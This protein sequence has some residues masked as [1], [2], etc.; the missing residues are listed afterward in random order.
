MKIVDIADEIFQEL[1]EASN[2]SIPAIA[3]WL[4][5]NVGVLNNFIN[6]TYSVDSTTYELNDSDSV[7]IG[8]NEKAILKKMYFVH[9]Y[10]LKIRENIINISSDSVISVSDD[11]S[12]VTKINKNEIT[13]ALSQIKRQEYDQ[14]Q[15]LINAYKLDKSSP[16]QV[17]GD[18]TEIGS[19]LNYLG[20]NEFNRSKM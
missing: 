7:E 12:S 15:D 18:D 11:G 3:F 2:I 13:K 4:R 14:L 20:S 1:N 9:Y 19:K 5:N 10:D 6:T 16:M 17:A 8:E